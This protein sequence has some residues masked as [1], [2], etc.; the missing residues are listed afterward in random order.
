MLH[1][2]ATLFMSNKAIFRLF[3]RT[4]TSFP[5]GLAKVIIDTPIANAPL[6]QKKSSD[7]DGAF[8]E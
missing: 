2:T 4:E 8:D 3:H 5:S 6:A 1:R 7:K